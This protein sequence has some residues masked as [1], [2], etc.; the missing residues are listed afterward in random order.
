M[1]KLS[2]AHIAL[3][4]LG[5]CKGSPSN[6][7]P[8]AVSASPAETSAT[9]Q[10]PPSDVI[11][12]SPKSPT[13]APGDNTYIRAFDEDAVD[14]TPPEFSFGRTGSGAPG[15]WIVKAAAGAPS[16]ANVLAQLDADDT[17][18]RFPIA[19]TNSPVLRDVRVS[20]RC[21]MI[22]GRVDQACG[23]VARY[24]DEN[25]YFVTRANALEDNIRLY[26]V[27]DGKRNEIASQDVRV[28]PNC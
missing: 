13:T 2:P 21:K 3:L 19:V 6:T 1:Q 7:S 16:G 8:P 12:A 11:E 5:A 18:F 25:N 22:S 15:R 9:T 10:S 26:T 27:R 28:T 14:T 24:R 23:L 4:V 20:V 17:N